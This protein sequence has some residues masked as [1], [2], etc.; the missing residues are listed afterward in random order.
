MIGRDYNIVGSEE[1]LKLK[2]DEAQGNGPV[3]MKFLNRDVLGLLDSKRV[4]HVVSITRGLV[5]RVISDPHDHIEDEVEDGS[6]DGNEDLLQDR[7]VNMNMNDFCVVNES[8]SVVLVGRSH[9]MDT[10]RLSD[11]QIEGSITREGEPREMA[12][13]SFFPTI[14]E[15]F[16]IGHHAFL[17]VLQSKVH[18]L[19]ILDYE[20]SKACQLI[21]NTLQNVIWT[22]E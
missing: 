22:G 21:L 11:W 1:G 15:S 3:R 4:L 18:R 17:C 9:Q 8:S 6:E 12:Q 20:G 13:S 2:I 10:M 7:N 19:Q 16:S 14:I 5:T